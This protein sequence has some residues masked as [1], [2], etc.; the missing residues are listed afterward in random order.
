MK[1]VKDMIMNKINNDINKVIAN[2]NNIQEEYYIEDL[3]Y[4]K[5]NL[6]NTINQK[7]EKKSNFKNDDYV[8]DIITKLKVVESANSFE[9]ILTNY[10]VRDDFYKKIQNDIENCKKLNNTE[11][12]K[13]VFYAQQKLLI[14][15]FTTDI[16]TYLKGEI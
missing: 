4:I 15:K 12:I 1:L 9:E 6:T 16:V 3:E 2:I 11:I 7:E 13:K 8:V 10:G 14:E 5:N